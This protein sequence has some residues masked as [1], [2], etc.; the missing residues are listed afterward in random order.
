MRM[1]NGTDEREALSAQSF[2]AVNCQGSDPG[3]RN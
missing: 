1:H 2:T 3:V